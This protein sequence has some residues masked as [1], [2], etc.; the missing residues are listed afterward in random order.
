MKQYSPALIIKSFSPD[1]LSRVI[2]TFDKATIAI[3]AT[4]W[5]ATIVMGALALFAVNQSVAARDA[6]DHAMAVEPALPI[7]SRHPMEGREGQ[8]VLTRFTHRYPDLVVNY[9]DAFIISATDGSKYQEW[10]TS[11]DYLESLAPKY[12]WQISELC[13]GTKCG[14][15]VMTA[16][17]KGDRIAFE[18]PQLETK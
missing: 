11:L 16:V 3:V 9:K 6:A 1:V 17:L 7:M 5:A 8:A 15:S 2:M 12:Q 18:M 14:Q 4:C 13:I 10:V